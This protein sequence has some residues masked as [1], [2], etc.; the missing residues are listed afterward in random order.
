M[1]YIPSQRRGALLLLGALFAA[2]CSLG[3]TALWCAS[4][5]TAI[6]VAAASLLL[7]ASAAWCAVRLRAAELEASRARIE[8]LEQRLA[9]RPSTPERFLRNLAHEIKTPLAVVLNQAELIL[10][11][12]DDRSVVQREAKSIADYLVHLA[13]LFDGFLRLGSS[14]APGE[15]LHP[16]PVHLHDTLLEAVRRSQSTARS[17]GVSI[18]PTFVETS[19]EEGSPRIAGDPA[20]IE[21]MIENLVRNAVRRSPRGGRVEVADE[22]HENRVVL[23]IRDHGAAIQPAELH[24]AFEWHSA[25]SDNVPRG[26]SPGVGL[27]I[28]KRVAEHHHGTLTLRN[29]LEGGCEFVVSL[30]RWSTEDAPLPA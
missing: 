16:V 15:V 14:E 22:L 21:A 6:W 17:H 20:L 11:C 13:A 12:S 28:A 26:A 23:R 25:M 8:Q 30:P 19:D 3:A 1:N 29:H 24:A 4:A 2:T 10:R 7:V 27:A 18:V 9:E 5:A